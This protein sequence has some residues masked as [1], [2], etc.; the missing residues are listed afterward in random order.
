MQLFV[1]DTGF[2]YVYPMKSKSEI[3]NAVKAFAKEIGVPTSLILGPEGT[4]KS[5]K[6]RK[7]DQEMG[8]SLK[9]I[10]RK[11]QWTNLAELYIR[12]LKEGV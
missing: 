10:E 9:F 4:K 1:S 3:P 5:E 2:T 11:T 6:L 12:I 7:T 8:C